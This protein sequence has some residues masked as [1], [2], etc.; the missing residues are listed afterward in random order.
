M[1]YT[2]SFYHTRVYNKDIKNT[3]QQ[4]KKGYKIMY[5]RR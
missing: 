4:Q 3:K 2:V 1:G 5:R